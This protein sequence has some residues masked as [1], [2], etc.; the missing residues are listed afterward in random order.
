MAEKAFSDARTV[1]KI[2]LKNK[3]NFAN[4]KGS[5]NYVQYNNGSF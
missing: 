1:A 5:S 2:I 4:G 3:T